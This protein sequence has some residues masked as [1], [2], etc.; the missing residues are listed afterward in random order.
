MKYL[1]IIGMFYYYRIITQENIPESNKFEKL[2][3]Y[4][5]FNL[6]FTLILTIIILAIWK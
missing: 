5:A 3:I 1:P 2:T 6:T 4:N